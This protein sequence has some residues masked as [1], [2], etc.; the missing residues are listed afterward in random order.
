M[1]VL[2]MGNTHTRSRHR[3]RWSG[4][5]SEA[6]QANTPSVWPSTSK[7]VSFSEQIVEQPQAHTSQIE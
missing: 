7:M 3:R 1:Y 5:S 4:S 2:V 6:P